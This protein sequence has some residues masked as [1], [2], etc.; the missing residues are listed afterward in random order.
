MR[1]AGRHVILSFISEMGE[2]GELLGARVQQCKYYPPP[3]EVEPE[4]AYDEGAFA[5]V[6]AWP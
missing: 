5:G 3:V 2:P 1:L 6:E 4:P